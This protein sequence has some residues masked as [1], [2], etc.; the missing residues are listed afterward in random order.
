MPSFFRGGS[1]RSKD[2]EKDKAALQ[3]PAEEKNLEVALT[4]LGAYERVK[5]QE[6]IKEAGTNVSGLIL[7]L[8]ISLYHM[9]SKY[10]RFN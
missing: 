4:K 1:F 7:C 5:S 10:S 9:F 6:V 3:P 2:K 8:S